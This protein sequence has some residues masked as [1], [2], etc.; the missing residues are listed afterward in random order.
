MS[1]LEVYRTG[2][3]AQVLIVLN[4]SYEKDL[5][6]PKCFDQKSKSECFV[7]NMTCEVP[8]SS[9]IKRKKKNQLP[10]R[11]FVKR[12]GLSTKCKPTERQ[13][14]HKLQI[15]LIK[16]KKKGWIIIVH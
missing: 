3:S 5:S 16:M 12:G 6:K 11:Q 1:A 13:P 14:W 4:A 10:M 2:K 15:V 8:I 9:V 7:S